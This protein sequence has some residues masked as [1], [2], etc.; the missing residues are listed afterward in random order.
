MQRIVPAAISILA[1]LVGTAWAAGAS[2][3]PGG[4]DAVAIGSASLSTASPVGSTSPV[5]MTPVGAL[6][7][8]AP[9][10]PME[11]TIA[12][13]L[14]PE[15]AESLTHHVHAGLLSVK[16]GERVAVPAGIGIDYLEPRCPGLP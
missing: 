2:P 8:P 11:L 7:W 5:P 14:S 9:P 15:R 10:D 6:L 12:A 3:A 16:D 1:V 4:T 13:G